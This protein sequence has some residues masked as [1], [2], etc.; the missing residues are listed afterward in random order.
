MQRRV[1]GT[2]H[3]P[4]GEVAVLMGVDRSGGLGRPVDVDLRVHVG[5][6]VAIAGGKDRPEGPMALTG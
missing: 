6:A 4:M 3:P 5:E 1:V 2:R